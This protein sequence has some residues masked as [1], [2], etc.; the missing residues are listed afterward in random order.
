MIKRLFRY[1]SYTL[2]LLLLFALSC[3]LWIIYSTEALTQDTFE[4]LEGYEVALVLGT[5][6]KL[7]GGKP[8]PFFHNRIKKAAELYHSGIVKKLILSGDHRTRY[9][10]E[11]L[12]MKKAIM[13]LGVPETSILLDYAGLRTL[14]SILRC[15]EVF[16]QEKFIVVTQKF[17]IY[18]SLFISN[19]YG[20]DAVG[21]AAE[22]VPLDNSFK[23]IVREFFARTKAVLDLYIFNTQV[24]DL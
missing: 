15:K 4:S 6:K 5:S 23:V 2:I 7:V 12:D 20:I 24:S 18:R 17:H 9:Y 14:D 22:G 3:N 1:F 21:V 11:P 10:N 16:G 13:E 19:Y 8:N